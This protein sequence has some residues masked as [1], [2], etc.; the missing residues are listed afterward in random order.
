MKK[1]HSTIITGFIS[2]LYVIQEHNWSIQ[3]VFN[4]LALDI[5][6]NVYAL[7]YCV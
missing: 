2:K 1:P 3:M 7:L 6:S 4:I 5:V